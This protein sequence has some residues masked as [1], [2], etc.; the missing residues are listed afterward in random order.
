MR[1]YWP[2]VTALSA[3][4]TLIVAGAA[5]AHVEVSPT[6]VSPGSSERFTVDVAGEKSVPAI[7]VRLEI[8][9]GFEVTD[10]RAPAGWQ[11]QLEDGSVVWD[12]GELAEDRAAEFTFD[13]RTPEEEGEY[14]WKGFVTYRDDSVVEWT[15]PPSSERPASVVT[16]GSGD[17]QTAGSGSEDH[18]GTGAKAAE[19]PDTGG[20]N[21]AIL[22]VFAALTIITA[23]L[24]LL[25]KSRI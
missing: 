23:G 19:M 21:P 24:V 3:L 8:P 10:V 7:E 25:R 14:A 12:G 11:G 18:H 17:S 2:K 9:K 16:V 5:W 1:T 20:V 13:A 15:G 4:L 22:Y 6:G